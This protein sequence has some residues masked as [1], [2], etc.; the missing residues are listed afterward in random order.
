MQHLLSGAPGPSSPPSPPRPAPAPAGLSAE[1]PAPQPPGRASTVSYLQVRRPA[2]RLFGDEIR[3]RKDEYGTYHLVEE[4]AE[5]AR[6]PVV[7][8]PARGR[9]WYVG[10]GE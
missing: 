3:L 9:S 8:E 1:S 5:E 7:G 6:R 10:E 4:G 2:T